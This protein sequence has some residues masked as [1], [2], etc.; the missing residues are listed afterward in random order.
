MARRVKI[1][2]GE[3]SGQV[4]L[5][6][7]A[8]FEPL[9]PADGS[10]KISRPVADAILSPD[11]AVRWQAGN[12][13]DAILSARAAGFVIT[14]PFRL[15]DLDRITISATSKAIALADADE[16]AKRNSE[17]VED[18]LTRSRSGSGSPSPIAS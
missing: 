2:A 17:A 14:T 16:I 8:V 9:P 10:E 1:V 13:R 6:G 4:T 12:L 3:S 5:S 18:L 15:D 7:P 11:E